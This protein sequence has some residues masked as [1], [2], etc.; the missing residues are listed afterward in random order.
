MNT[1]SEE[2]QGALD[3]SDLDVA[4]ESAIRLQR[5]KQLVGATREAGFFARIEKLWTAARENDGSDLLKALALLFRI[6]AVAKHIRPRF[7]D[8]ASQVVSAPRASPHILSD[9]DDRRY[10]GEA[11][12]FASGPW[13]ANYAAKAAVEEVSGEE[14]RDQFV[15]VLVETLG[16]LSGCIVSLRSEFESWQ[17][18]TQDVGTSRARRMTRVISAL[19]KAVIERDPPVGAELGA[20]LLDFARSAIAGEPMPS[21]R[22][23]AVSRSSATTKVGRH[24][25]WSVLQTWLAHRTLSLKSSF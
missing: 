10:L 17:V 8:L 13:K 3:L 11:L 9:S 7:E 23:W 5:D 1:P 20:G 14:A 6:A 22:S 18:D 21:P 4:R 15:A 2:R 24:R 25:P 12:M 19:K 16:S